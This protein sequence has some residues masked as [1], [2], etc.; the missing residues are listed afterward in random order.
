MIISIS[1]KKLVGK[2][3]AADFLVKTFGFKKIGLADSLKEI[4]SSALG[5]PLADFH[6]QT[7]KELPL[8]TWD[9]YPGLMSGDIQ[10]ILD[11][12]MIR[13]PLMDYEKSAVDK[14]FTKER[15]SSLRDLM[16]KFGTEC[17]RTLIDQDIWL[18]ILQSQITD[19]DQNLVCCDARFPNERKFFR[20]LGAKLWMI[21][22]TLPGK[23][24]THPSENQ[25][26]TITDYD[27]IMSNNGTFDD[28]EWIVGVFYNMD[29]TGILK[30]DL[31]DDAYGK[32]NQAPTRRWKGRNIIKTKKQIKRPKATSASAQKSD[33]GIGKKVRKSRPTNLRIRKV[34]KTAKRSRK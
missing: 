20:E 32:N 4:L 34:A 7:K 33:K 19:C 8:T 31:G 12:I 30:L 2:D 21:E 6:D 1:G 25:L 23:T 5:I 28:L 18:K 13:F 17:C 15:F 29:R 3:T 22:R 16:Q 10:N 27:H 24:D 14:F 9:K 26:G 11:E